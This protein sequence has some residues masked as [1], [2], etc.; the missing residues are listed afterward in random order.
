MG[1]PSRRTETRGNSLQDTLPSRAQQLQKLGHTFPFFSERHDCS[2]K[3]GYAAG[4][5]SLANIGRFINS[6]P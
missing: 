4:G 6:R 3:T 5:R 1:W 2:V